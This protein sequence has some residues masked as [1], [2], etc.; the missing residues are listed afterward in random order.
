MTNTVWLKS[1]K[2]NKWTNTTVKPKATSPLLMLTFIIAQGIFI[3]LLPIISTPASRLCSWKG[4][5][6]KNH[7]KSDNKIII[8]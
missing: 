6:S 8:I 7:I 3:V 4:K 2:L 5:E 1:K